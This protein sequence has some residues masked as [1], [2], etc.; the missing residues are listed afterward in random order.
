MKL[1]YLIFIIL[2]STFNSL[3]FYNASEF[4]K[5][6]R[7]NTPANEENL[8]N[9]I[10]N[11]L[12]FLKHYVFYTIAQ[13]PPQPEFAP[14]YFPKIDIMKIFSKIKTNNTNLFDFKNEF[15]SA[16]YELNDIHIIPL[17]DLIPARYYQYL[18]PINLYTRYDKKNDTTKMYGS[19]VVNKTIYAYFKDHEHVVEIIEKNLNNS[20]KSINGKDP[21]TFIQEFAGIKM[22]NKHSTYVFK[23]LACKNYNFLISATE[24]DLTNF[25]FVYSNGDNFTTDYLIID[26]VPQSNNIQYYEDEEDNKKYLSYLSNY[27]EKINSLTS[28]NELLA[29]Y[30]S[31]GFNKI[32]LD[33]ENIYNITSNNLF[34]QKKESKNAIDWTYS[35]KSRSTGAILFQCRVDKIN[36]VNV[37]KINSF[38]LPI[39]SDPSLDVSEQCAYLFDENDYRIVIIFPRNAGGNPVIGYNIIELLSPYILTRNIVRMKK[40]LNMDKII[41]GYNLLDLFVELNSTKKVTADYI[42]DGFVQEKYG[43][44]IEEF[45]KPFVW[46]VNQKRI[47]KIKKKLKHKRIPTEIVIMT[48]GYALSAASIFMKNA[49]KSGAGIII[50]YNGNP[51]L[52]DDIYDISQSPS[53]LYGIQNY[54]DIY[55]EIYNNTVKYLMGLSTITCMVTYHEFQESHIPQ[56]YD[57]QNPDKRIKIF[58]PYD[59]EKYQEFIDE[60]IIVLDSYKENCNPKHEM[61]VLF[62]DECKFD[63]ELLHGGF[64]CGSDS[65]WDRSKCIPVYCDPGYY[66]NKISN[67]CIEYP[68][69]EDGD[70]EESESEKGEGENEEEE[71][72]KGEGENE[73]EEESESKKGDENEEEESE[74]EHE[75]E[76][77]D[78]KEGE[79]EHEDERRDEDEQENEHEDEHENEN[80]DG[81]NNENNKDKDDLAVWKI[82][83]IVVACGIFIIVFVTLIVLYKKNLLC[84]KKEK[85]K[86]IVLIII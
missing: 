24:E 14:S 68:M 75:R 77:K 30:H 60:A 4:I 13:D 69:E 40:D 31:K 6:L 72:E 58:N 76:N 65:K 17:F 53:A 27:N 29:D 2:L 80:E 83:V 7:E 85:N 66:Y 59:D 44:K 20:I 26:S 19:L 86:I 61:L 35:Y 81:G 28:Q 23:Q 70:E 37:M 10:N 82:A 50:G 46:R 67:S 38:G 52:P 47:E 33:F 9:G 1:S 8:L 84:F 64:A 34:F 49:Y 42:K 78:E 74:Y 21:F 43:D 55:P 32:M 71:S 63:N 5:Y 36:K 3:R 45:S 62:S 48:D 54:K 39:D 56:E 51:T 79:N 11:T 22:R 73:E 16:L 41:E 15:I 57:I 18:C 25:T 12:E